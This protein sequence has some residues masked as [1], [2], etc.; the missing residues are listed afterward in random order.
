MKGFIAQEMLKV[1]PEA[2]VKQADGYY[3]VNYDAVVPVLV[4]A[5]KQLD[6]KQAETTQLQQQ[7]TALQ[8]QVALLQAAVQKVTGKSVGASGSVDF[9]PK[10]FSLGQNV[11]NPS[12]GASRIDY[13]LPAGASGAVIT[14]YDLQGQMLKTF[15][16]LTSGQPQT[17]E[18]PAGTLPAGLYIYKL[19]VNGIEIASKRL[20][21]AQ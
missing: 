11:P 2:V 18:L 14:V 10:Q 5:V 1:M 20:Q 13:S 6:A 16:N 4:E 12:P 21:L 17:I 19:T 9:D 3:A 15:A 8:A 7:L